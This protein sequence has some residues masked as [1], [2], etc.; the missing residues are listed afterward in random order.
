MIYKVNWL[1]IKL[2]YNIHIHAIYDVYFSVRTYTVYEL[3]NQFGA[4]FGFLFGNDLKIILATFIIVA[5]AKVIL[6]NS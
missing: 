5:I 1:I 6:H 3:L 2:L 4:A